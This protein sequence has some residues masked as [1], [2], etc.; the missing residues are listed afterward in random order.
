MNEFKEVNP[1]VPVEPTEK[2]ATKVKRIYRRKKALEELEKQVQR[3]SVFVAVESGPPKSEPNKSN[4]RDMG[5]PDPKWMAEFV[6]SL[7]GVL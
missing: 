2:K 6:K 7:L 5:L 1:V 3:P 4:R